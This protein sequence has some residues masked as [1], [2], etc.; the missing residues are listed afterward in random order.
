[1]L[2]PSGLELPRMNY[3]VNG[4]RHRFV[5]GNSV[6]ESAVS[7]KVTFAIVFNLPIAWRD[8]WDRAAL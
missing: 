4:K 1:M 8:W 5:Y 2:F 6:E 7:K 3:D